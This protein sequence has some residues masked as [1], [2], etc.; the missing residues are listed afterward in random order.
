MRPTSIRLDDDLR[1]KMKR[2]SHLRQM[3]IREIIDAALKEYFISESFET[4]RPERKK[5]GKA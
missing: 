2:F 5:A 1:D 3:S 4:S